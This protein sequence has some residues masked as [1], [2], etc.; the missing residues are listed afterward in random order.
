MCVGLPLDFTIGLVLV[1]VLIL[2]FFLDF[3]LVLDLDLGSTYE[4]LKLTFAHDDSFTNDQF[5]SIY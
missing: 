1:L 3:F 2:E 5:V 4:H